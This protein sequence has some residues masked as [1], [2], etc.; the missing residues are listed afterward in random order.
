MSVGPERLALLRGHVTLN[1]IDLV[2]VSDDQTQLR[3]FFINP[4]SAAL[5]TALAPDRVRITPASIDGAQAPPLVVP[6]PPVLPVAWD[7]TGV[8]RHLILTFTEPGPFSYQRLT[9]DHSLIDPFFG[10]TLFNFKAGC[11]SPFDCREAPDCPEPDRAQPVIDYMARD[12]ESFRRVLLDHAATHWPEWRERHLP[13]VGNMLVDLMA[14]FGSELAY[15]QD[16]VARE[17]TLVGAT[18][19][20]SLRAHARLMDYEIA[21]PLAAHGL[22][23]VQVDPAGAATSGVLTAG[24]EVWALTTD[25][26]QIFYEI[27]LGLAD[28]TAPDTYPVDAALNAVPPHLFDEDQNCLF[29]GAT[30]FVVEG[31]LSA[32]LPLTETLADGTP[33]RRLLLRTDPEIGLT[34]ESSGAPEKRALVFAIGIKDDSDPLLGA[35]ITRITLADPLPGDLDL[36]T[37]TMRGNLVP[38]SAGRTRDDI[39][40]V[41]GS[42]ADAPPA[43]PDAE[44]AALVETIERVGPGDVPLHRLFLTGTDTEP[45][46]WLSPG[47]AAAARPAVEVTELSWTGAAFSDE[48]TWTWRRSLLGAPS[49][50]PDSLDYTLEDG[51]WEVVR[52]FSHLNEPFDWRD[53]AGPLGM[54]LRF[55]DGEF[56]MAPIRGTM[57]RLR[58]KTGGG[59]VSNLGADTVRHIETA[60]LPAGM[61]V[62]IANPFALGNG[63]DAESAEEAR[64]AAPEAWKV[65]TYRAVRPED[66]SEAAERLD[67]VDRASTR[68]LWTGSWLSTFTMP[69]PVDRSDLPPDRRAE[70][71]AWLDRFR[72]TGRDA[73][74]ADPVYAD[75]DFEITICVAPDRERSDVARRVKR[76]LSTAPGGF[77]DPNDRSFGDA[78][79]RARL[80]AA[81]HDAGG[82]RAVEAIRFRRRGWF[83]WRDFGTRY[84]PEGSSEIIRV[85]NDPGRPER[86]TITLLVEGGA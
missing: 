43:L 85:D 50:L 21:P 25:G 26:Q 16:R 11:P 22:L 66:Y 36:T 28:L 52:R 13:D 49:S 44:R 12:F 42:R 3:V 41:A 17:T 37:L 57:F 59:S 19:P 38:I 68:S 78:V 67:W 40:L 47:G 75:L 29:R 35:A 56:G 14:Y 71:D 9:L 53:Y 31:A 6:D 60:D 27:G 84:V 82:V 69:D 86:G 24:T 1:G 55:G 5:Q 83:D 39:L 79:E 45:L 64:I 4:P 18:Q 72:M 81:I 51:K 74:L 32:L 34:P 30:E 48:N 10:T 58:Y 8:G 65:E 20:R 80:E 70:L 73:R 61:S 54:T 62:T 15:Y 46:V 33:A 77:F 23:D 63:R 7:G 76:R 2:V